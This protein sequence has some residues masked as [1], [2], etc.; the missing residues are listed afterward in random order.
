MY[1]EEAK[2]FFRGCFGK[3]VLR[4]AEQFNDFHV[5]ITGAQLEI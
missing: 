2:S 4:H 3:I 1:L 5:T